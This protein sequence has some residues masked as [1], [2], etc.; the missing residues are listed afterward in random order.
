MVRKLQQLNQTFSTLN[1]VI[2]DSATALTLVDGSVF[3]TE[4]EFP[5]AIDNEI[6]LCTSRTGNVITVVRGTE[7]T[8]AA[9]HASG[10]Y[11]FAL[12]TS[13]SMNKFATDFVLPTQE[14]LVVPDVI[15]DSN[16]DILTKAD[17]TEQNISTSTVIDETW[18]GITIGARI[19]IFVGTYLR[20]LTRTQPSTPYT[21]TAHVKGGAGCGFQSDVKRGQM[22]GIGW[23]E[24]SSGKNI[25]C[26]ARLDKEVTW[27]QMD[28]WNTADPTINH[29]V[30][31]YYRED[32]WMRL[33]NDGVTLTM[34]V[35]YD[36]LNFFTLGSESVGTYITP[37]TIFFFTHNG[38]TSGPQRY[39]SLLGWYEN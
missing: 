24:S 3:P 18:G 34:E 11:V 15:Q 16:G 7:N 8:E 32:C 35:S 20:K 28:A 13:Y 36:G 19:E 1:G 21:V 5:V 31:F 33:T 38:L 2:T 37:D 29:T 17:F 10:A 22:V 25:I 12:A 27:S 6:M 30:P 4:G 14:D 26:G 9:A 23:E 39:G